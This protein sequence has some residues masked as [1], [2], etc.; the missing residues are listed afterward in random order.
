MKKDNQNTYS[1]RFGIIMAVIVLISIVYIS[2]LGKMDLVDGEVYQT[3]AMQYT[4]NS[5]TITAARGEIV[6]RYGRAI[7]QN[8]MGYTVYF[9]RAE[10]PKGSENETIWQLCSI[11]KEADEEW[12]DNCPIVI[13]PSGYASYT[14]ESDKLISK[15]K[16]TLTLQTYATA[17][18]CLDT[19][20][21]KFEVGNLPTDIAREIMGV[22]LNMLQMEFSSANPYIFA[23]DVSLET[24][25]KITENSSLL[26]GVY[27]EVMPIREYVDGTVAPHL[28]GIT[29]SI[30]AEEY[31][32][33]KEE[34]YSINAIIGKFGVEKE[35]EKYLRGKNGLRKVQRDTNGKIVYEYVARDA[36]PG[37]TVVLTIDSELQKV[38]QNSLATT[39]QSI[40]AKG[41]LTDRLDGEDADAGALV[42]MNCRTFEVLAAVTYPSYNLNEYLSN[43]DNLLADKAAPLYNRAINGT[44]APGSTFKPA[45]A[46]A[47]LQTGIIDKNTKIECTGRYYLAEYDN[48][49]LKCLHVHGMLDVINAIG[50]S[51]N[52]FFYDTGYK[53]GITRLNDYCKQ[54]GFGVASGIGMGES[55]GCLAGREERE[56]KEENW[57][58]ADTLT[59]S[60]GQNDNKFTPMQLCVYV[61]TIAN[62]GTRYEARLVK[63]IKSFDMID[64]VVAD[65][66]EN[67]VVYNALN[68]DKSY[69]NLVKRGM[70]AVTKDES[71][72]ASD[73]FN[74]YKIQVGG[75]TGTAETVK[76]KYSANALFLCFA[77]FDEPEIAI[78]IVGER[79]AYGSYM[80]I[81]ARDIMDEYFFSEKT[82]GYNVISENQIIA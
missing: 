5:V 77:P 26:P 20:N 58:A 81:V 48:F 15:M 24:A 28:I 56:A 61:S 79:C 42:V 31:E 37:N 72:T 65:T 8:R 69:I 34:G 36:V 35:Y 23:E 46:L 19:M 9:S 67:P 53:I 11:L 52:V 3:K 44:Y 25:Q 41:R 12:I 1:V 49:Y 39:I 71:G 30:F 32:K 68:I 73:T 13:S 59:A 66:S 38:A 45:V 75:K 76:N 16:S 80:A 62:G 29:G 57:Y 40:A 18:N 4:A 22:R 51:C 33:L 60:I 63:T 54:L 21:E 10:M 78:A 43:Y 14:E 17:Q 7:S 2:I 82:T 47:G 27:V 74:N 70:L 50:E 64:T 6:D 55:K